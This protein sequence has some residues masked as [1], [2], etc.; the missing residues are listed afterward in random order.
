MTANDRNDPAQPSG[1][2]SSRRRG[3]LVIGIV[4]A[5]LVVCTLVLSVRA[6]RRVNRTALSASSRAVT[7]V[8][9]RHSTFRPS[10]TYVGTVEPWLE[11]S[12]GPQYVSAYVTTVL[13]RPGAVV[14]RGQVL[15]T[16]DCA[17]PS[18]KSRAIAMRAQ[19]MDAEMQAATRE[20]E[21]VTSMLDG[22]FVAPNEAEKKNA[23]GVASQAQLRETEATL[24]SAALDVHDCILRAPF[25]GEVGTRSFDPGAFVHPG[26]SIVSIVDR[27]TVRVTVDAPEKDFDSLAPPTPVDVHFLAVQSDLAAPISRRAPRAEARAR[28]IHVEIDIPDPT[29]QYP[30]GTTA[31]V[32]VNVGKPIAATEIPIYAATLDGDKARLFVVEGG[33]A[34]ARTVPVVGEV[35][36]SLFLEPT[37]I[38]DGTLVVTEGRALLSDGDPVHHHQEPKAPEETAPSPPGEPLRRGGGF[39]RPL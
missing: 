32:R 16:L 2:A 25:A 20:A 39:G 18:A 7:V 19:A 12:V 23:A 13:V 34:H 30:V 3:L 36:A 29:R 10:R 21:R 38:P 1:A 37:A 22:G 9:A 33:V 31:L 6:E 14:R 5:A 17:N 26:A 11:A 27:G 15:A 28:T 4:T 8:R 24:A 35:G